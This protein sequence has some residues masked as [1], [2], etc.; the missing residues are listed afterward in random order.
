VGELELLRAFVRALVA[1]RR[2]WDEFYA[3]SN[4]QQRRTVELGEG[5]TEEA[6]REALRLKRAHS[7]LRTE[8]SAAFARVAEANPE[9]VNGWSFVSD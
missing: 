8:V 5:P 1:E 9:L 4:D 6:A 3:Y 7:A 2:A